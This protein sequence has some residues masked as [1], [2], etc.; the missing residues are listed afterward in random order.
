MTGLDKVISVLQHFTEA[1][2]DPFDIACDE[3]MSAQLGAELVSQENLDLRRLLAMRTVPMHELDIDYMIGSGIDFMRDT[4]E[5]IGEKLHNVE[6]KKIK[7]HLKGQAQRVLGK[8]KPVAIL[9]A[10]G[11]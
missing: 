1:D 6:A 5:D 3:A 2:G 11:I 10:E 9:S 8:F 7:E 4:P